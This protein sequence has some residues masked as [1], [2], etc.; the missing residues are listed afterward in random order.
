MSNKRAFSFVE[1][2]VAFSL[3]ALM[4]AL[5]L[6][7]TYRAMER[8][9]FEYSC[10]L[11]KEKAKECCLRASTSERVLQAKIEFSKGRLVF[12]GLALDDIKRVTLDGRPVR[13]EVVTVFPRTGFAKHALLIEGPKSILL[14]I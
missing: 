5:V 6:R 8:M 10:R 9:R 2:I 11:L 1:L 13:D 4:A 3:V 12:D 14:N 7:P